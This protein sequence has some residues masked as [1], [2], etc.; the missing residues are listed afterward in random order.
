[1][2][3]ERLLKLAGILNE[4]FSDAEHYNKKDAHKEKFE[5][6]AIVVTDL[7]DGDVFGFLGHKR[8]VVSSPL[9]RGYGGVGHVDEDE[10]EV[11][12]V[13]NSLSSKEIA[14]LKRWTLNELNE[15]TKINEGRGRT[16]D[17]W[18]TAIHTGVM[19]AVHLGMKNP[20]N[21]MA[22]DI[23]DIVDQIVQELDD[24]V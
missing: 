6:R 17:D 12:D 11:S 4:D 3:K 10:V 22:G 13:D 7:Y 16:M 18:R 20:D 14:F 19:K 24:V 23:K 15:S 8:F 5:G 2:N 21:V 9:D 1:M